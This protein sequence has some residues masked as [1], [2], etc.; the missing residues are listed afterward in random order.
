MI[1]E[2][3]DELDL[4]DRLV[5]TGYLPEDD[6]DNPLRPKRLSEYI[7]QE[8]N[9]ENLSI[10]INAALQR[11]DVLD[12]V[13]LYGPPGTGKSQT[14]TSLITQFIHEGKTV[15]M[16]SEKKTALDVVYSRLGNLSRYAMMMDDSTN[17]NLFY[18]QL[19]K[20]LYNNDATNNDNKQNNN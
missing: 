5:S 6:A 13:L 15:L 7:G 8:K 20:L 12:H 3:N 2:G 19:E 16:V 9:K 1:Y 10:Y 4:E 11:H 17:K 18:S 14:I